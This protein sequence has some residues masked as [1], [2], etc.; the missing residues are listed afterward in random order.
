MAT[1]LTFLAA[2]VFVSHGNN[3]SWTARGLVALLLLLV[4]VNGVFLVSGEYQG[5]LGTNRDVAALSNLGPLLSP[6]QGDLIIARS[7]NVDDA[8]GWIPL[9]AASPVLSCA[10]AEVMLTPQPNRNVHR[11]RQALYLYLSREDSRSLERELSVLDPSSL[12]YRLG[13]WAEAVSLSPEER[14]Q[15]IH[16]IQTDLIPLLQKVEQHDVMATRF[17]H[18]FARVIVI[19]K[20]Q[21]RSFSPER[22]ASFLQ[23]EGQQEGRGFVMSFYRPK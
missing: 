7:T 16:Q 13:Y 21:E 9:I 19:D 15:G 20:Q 18:D 17:F 22:L 11:F 5:F 14:T 6:R 8:C 23:L 4:F 12:M 2:T 3:Q 10:D 1:L